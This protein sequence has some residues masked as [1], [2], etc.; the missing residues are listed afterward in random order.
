MKR[1]VYL[2]FVFALI[3]LGACSVRPAE[4]IRDL[5]EWST[6]AG[7]LQVQAPKAGRDKHLV[8]V[9]AHNAG[10]ETTDFVIPYAV[11]QQSGLADVQTAAPSA[12][13]VP[14]FPA[15]NVQIDQSLTDFDSRYPDGADIVIVPAY[16]QPDDAEITDWLQ[17]QASLGALIVGICDGTWSLAHAGLL[18][19]RLATGHWFSLNKLADK[20]EATRWVK[21]QRYVQDGNVVTTTG[22]SASIPVSLALVAAM[23]DDNTAQELA[24]QMGETPHA[25][26]HDSESFSLGADKLLHALGNRLQFWN[27]EIRLLGIEHDVDDIALALTADAW[28]RTWRS[29][30]LTS[31]TTG[32]AEV[33][34]KHGLKIVVDRPGADAVQTVAEPVSLHQ[35]LAD[36]SE[37]YG[38]R[39]SEFV[40]VQLEYAGRSV[41]Q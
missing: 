36:I 30:A 20:F 7:P 22:V 18:D 39:T 19:Q 33:R 31:S 4:N 11:V 10:A 25:A 35:V 29:R 5:N 41:R 3:A 24:R 16:H 37:R 15:L 8:L 14:L 38:D 12:G 13:I 2:L 21:D 34:T 28:S 27:S 9:L 23:S 17:A 40:A 1:S 32:I 26:A 6:V